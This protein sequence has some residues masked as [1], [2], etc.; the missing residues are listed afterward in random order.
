M[1]NL[2]HRRPLSAN[3]P[4]N[5]CF[6][7]NRPIVTIVSHLKNI[8]INPRHACAARV[9]VLGLCV[10]VF[11][12]IC[13]LTHWNHKSEVPTNS[14]QYRK[15]KKAIYLKM[16]RSKVMTSYA[17]RNSPQPRCSILELAFSPAEILKLF[18]RLTVGSALPGIRV[19]SMYIGQQATAVI[20]NI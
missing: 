13:R 8:V 15:D 12:L 4:K 16:L 1:M 18:K 5:K 14:S 17:Y 19:Y 6:A 7:E 10:C 3:G 2:Q 9:T 11:A 20:A